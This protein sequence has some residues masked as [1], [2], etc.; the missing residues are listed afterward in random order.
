MTYELLL[1]DGALADRPPFGFKRAIV[2]VPC[3]T[4]LATFCFVSNA[5]YQHHIFNAFND[6]VHAVNS[7][8]C[9]SWRQTFPLPDYVRLKLD[10]SRVLPGCYYQKR[11]KVT[12]PAISTLTQMSIWKYVTWKKK[13]RCPKSQAAQL[14]LHFT[15]VVYRKQLVKMVYTMWTYCS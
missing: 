4:V 2:W 15:E 5:E 13:E 3:R 6:I 12:M 8:F 7:C 14:P 9:L 1:G 11:G 10:K